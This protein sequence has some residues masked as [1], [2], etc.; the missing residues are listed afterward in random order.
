M[1]IPLLSHEVRRWGRMSNEEYGKCL[2][3]KKPTTQRHLL[4]G[5]RIASGMLI[6]RHDIIVDE[7]YNKIIENKL[8]NKYDNKLKFIKLE[9]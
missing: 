7:I 1:G 6:K 2:E 3:C 8:Y 5:C 4:G 9:K